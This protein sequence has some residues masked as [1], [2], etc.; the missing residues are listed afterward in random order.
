MKII[1]SLLMV[2]LIAILVPGGGPRVSSA[3]DDPFV[4][5]RAIRME[6]GTPAHDFALADLEGTQVSLSDFRGKVVL[7]GFFTTT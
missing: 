4:A 5:L 3:Q 7:L 6:P 2:L 1:S